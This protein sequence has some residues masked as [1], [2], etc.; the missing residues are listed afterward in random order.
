MASYQ[1]YQTTNKPKNRPVL[2]LARVPEGLGR[3][4]PVDRR[5]LPV[6]QHTR[7]VHPDTGEEHFGFVP[8]IPGTPTED[9]APII[10][11]H[12]WQ[13]DDYSGM[14]AAHVWHRH[15]ED[16]SQHGAED[17]SDVGRFVADVIEQNAP[18]YRLRDER[19]E[20]RLGIFRPGIGL[21]VLGPKRQGNLWQWRVITAYKRSSFDPETAVGHVDMCLPAVA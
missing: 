21:V 17:V 16:A 12:G 20:A 10:L 9:Y 14:G 11:T 7:Y 4:V 15:A 5:V 3:R 18:I 13:S 2:R 8:P 19:G 1:Q 6:F